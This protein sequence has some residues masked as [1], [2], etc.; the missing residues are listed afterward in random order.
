MFNLLDNRWEGRHRCALHKRTILFSWSVCDSCD[1][2]TPTVQL[3]NEDTVNCS[4]G[5]PTGIKIPAASCFRPSAR[6]LEPH[7]PGSLRVR[8]NKLENPS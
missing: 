6:A 3:L 7:V 1:S 5:E 8:V 4:C 2:M